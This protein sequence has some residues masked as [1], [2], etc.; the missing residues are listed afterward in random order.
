MSTPGDNSSVHALRVKQWLPEWEQVNFDADQNQTKPEP[1]FYVFS[2]SA[3]RLRELSAIYRRDTTDMTARQEDL[4][5]Q[6]RHDPERSA[7]IQR[8][9]VEGYPRSGLS[10]AQRKD[11]ANDGLRK[12][13]WLPTAV[14]VN[15]LNEGDQ[16]N[17]QTIGPNHVI[18]VSDDPSETFAKLT[19]PDNVDDGLPP[20]EVIDGQHRLFA[21]DDDD[22]NVADFELPVVAFHGL[23]ISWQAYLFWTINIKPKKINA[24]LAFDLYPLLREQDWLDSGDRI[25]VYRE[26]RAQELTEVLWSTPESPWYKRINMLGGPRKESGP[27]TQAAFVRSLI[28][29]MVKP[30]KRSGR[31]ATGGIFG[32]TPN[33]NDGLAWSRVQQA[34]FLVTAWRLLADAIRKTRSDWAEALRQEQAQLDLLDEDPAFSGRYSFLATDQGVRGFQHVIN[35]LAYIREKPLGLAAWQDAGDIADVSP[36]S[37]AEIAKTIP[38]TIINF[39]EGIAEGLASYDWR[40]SG[41]P[42]LTES[43]RL[44]KAALRGSGGYKEMRE[45]LVT[46]LSSAENHDIANAAT[47]L[48]GWF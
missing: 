48:K 36:D 25:L 10:E 19:L 26:S 3:A 12:P 5:I 21:F 9:V 13:G 23:D 35:D 34:A 7:E 18:T 45:Q 44:G 4:G 32:G 16:R 33:Q 43:E 20:I 40:T 47:A 41:F 46:H 38:D 11:A 1:H 37:I 17:G 2:L 39:L 22:T 31:Q 14:V 27:V 42:G 6:R 15:I 30:W 29:S 28:A 24:S 8:Y